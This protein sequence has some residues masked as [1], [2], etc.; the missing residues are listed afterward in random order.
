M[1]NPQLRKNIFEWIDRILNKL[2]LNGIL[3]KQFI[4]LKETI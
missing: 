4:D 2:S 3:E 1:A